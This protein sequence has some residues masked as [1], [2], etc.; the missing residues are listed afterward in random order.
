MEP[1]KELRASQRQLAAKEAEL[2]DVQQLHE[3]RREKAVKG[4]EWE[5]RLQALQAREEMLQSHERL[6]LQRQSD[7]EGVTIL[8]SRS[9]HIL[10][11]RCNIMQYSILYIRDTLHSQFS[12]CVCGVL[13]GDTCVA[14]SFGG[15]WQREAAGMGCCW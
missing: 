13:R 8:Q 6:L 5:Q 11:Y 1:R 14:D 12:F 3:R 15:T 4:V 2:A 10:L 7:L 9:Y